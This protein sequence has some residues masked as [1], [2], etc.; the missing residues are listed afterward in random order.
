MAACLRRI[1]ITPPFSVAGP[2]PRP[3]Q[4]RRPL[5]HPEGFVMG[6]WDKL[7]REFIDIIQWTEPSQ[8]EVLA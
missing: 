8:N 4:Y 5:T 6:L 1:P 3:A 7:T 2:P